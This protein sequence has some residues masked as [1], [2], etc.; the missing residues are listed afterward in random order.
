MS[1]YLGLVFGDFASGFLS[2]RLGSRKKI[3]GA[4]LGATTLL[5]I[6]YLFVRVSSPTF[7]YMMCGLMG[8]AAGYWAVFV[9]VGAELFGTNLRATVATTSPNFVRG[10]VVLLT[11]AF[12]GLS[13]SMGLVFSALTVGAAAIVAAFWALRGLDETYGRDLD[14]VEQ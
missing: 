9:T 14:F 8:F 1:C 12:R 2:Q 7:I 10:A 5:V 6:V 13:G 3:V 4:F 11:L